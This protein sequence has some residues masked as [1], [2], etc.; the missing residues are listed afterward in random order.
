MKNY[1]HLIFI[2]GEWEFYHRREFT[3]AI[4]KNYSDWSYSVAVQYPVSLLLN[5]FFKFKKRFIPFVT[6]KNKPILISENLILF[7]PF[8][9]FHHKLWAKSKIFSYIDSYLLG[10][11]IRKFL[12]SNFNPSK[13]FAWAY[14]PQHIDLL[15]YINHDYIIYD[16]YDDNELNYDGTEN[17]KMTELNKKLVSNSV[18]TLCNAHSVIKKVSVYANNAIFVPS[19]INPEFYKKSN[20]SLP[21]IL[22]NV[23]CKIIGYLGN[24]RNW[25][26]FRLLEEILVS[27]KMCKLVLVGGVERNVV[28]EMEKLNKYDNFIHINHIQQNLTGS[29]S[30]K[31]SVGIIP[32]KINE[33]TL[34]VLPY[35]FY[36]YIASEIPIV[37]TP[38][39]ELERYKEICGFSENNE[40]FISNISD[41]ISGKKVVNQHEYSKVISQN[42]WT[43][44]TDKIESELK[45]KMF[46][47]INS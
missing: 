1:L 25:I 29:Y 23:D 14:I 31:F 17:K 3:K 34:S 47:K 30:R 38:L 46:L 39:P 8:I 35:K 40:K 27:F 16:M 4:A 5:L 45:E 7:T 18:L 10:I 36:E 33:F 28:N 19:A 42:S 41:Y 20:D 21:N 6:G 22:D 15:K 32:F 37:T 44:R 12:K 2:S 9:L 26:D 13:I 11:Q 24:I 43:N